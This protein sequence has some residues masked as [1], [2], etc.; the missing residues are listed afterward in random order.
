MI[1]DNRSCGY[2]VHELSTLKDVSEYKIKM[3]RNV[4]Y[5]DYL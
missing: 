1:F 5:C 4:L 2:Y 3:T